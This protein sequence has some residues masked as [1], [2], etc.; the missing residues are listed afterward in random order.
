MAKIFNETSV[1]AED[2]GK[3]VSIQHLITP[4]RVQSDNVRTEIVALQPGAGIDIEVDAKDI[5]WAHILEGSADLSGAAGAQA[6]SADHFLFFPPGFSG[7]IS[8]KSGAKLFRA[9]VPDAARFDPGWDPAKLGFRC[10]DWTE[11]PVLDSEHDARKRIYMVTPKLFGTDVVKGEMILYPAGTEASNHHHEG[12][13][14]FQYILRG[15]AE[16][17][18]NEEPH[19]V[20]AGDTVYIYANERHYFV[21]D[22]DDEMAFIEYFVPGIYKTIWAD[23]APICTWNPTGRNIMGGKPSREISAHSSADP[24]GTDV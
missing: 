15:S 3:G 16:F 8:S 21:N 13:D 9:T 6:L 22:G 7:A 24:D 2:L 20:K 1:A 14:H 12:A 19:R 4:E 11:E 18:L 23:N 5:A 17:F 10:V